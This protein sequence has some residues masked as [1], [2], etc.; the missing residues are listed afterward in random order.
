MGTI[1]AP[2][3][4]TLCSSTG[5]TSLPLPNGEHSLPLIEAE[6]WLCIDKTDVFLKG[7]AF[8]RNDDLIVMAAYPGTID[9]SMAGRVNRSLLRINRQREVSPLLSVTGIRMCDH[10]IHRDGRILIACLTGE[11]LVVNGDGTG[12]EHIMSRVGQKRQKL[13]DLT[14]DSNGFLYVTDFSGYATS[15][16]GGIYRWSPDFATVETLMPNLV[17]PNGIAFSPG[18]QSVWVSCSWSNEILLVALNESRSAVEKAAVTYRLSGP[19]G[20]DGIRTDVC[21]NMYLAVNFQGRILI[22]NKHGFP[23]ANVLMPRRERGELIRTSNMA[24][25]PGTDEVYVVASG[26]SGG[27]WIYRFRGLAQ[28]AQLFSHL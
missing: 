18:Q 6:P 16:Q 23:V 26:E 24:F 25:K 7:I 2:E 27:A 15:P 11:L 21:G 10:A 28:G 19:P 22:F 5:A 13:S 20:A 8:N 17:T 9:K 12:L 3:S 14:F 1:A 4:T